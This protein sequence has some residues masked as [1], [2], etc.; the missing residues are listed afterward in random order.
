MTWASL[1]WLLVGGGVVILLVLAYALDFQR[2][3]TLMARIG[4]APQIARMAA[5]VSN[6]KRIAKAIL[7]VTAVALIAV[8]LAGPRVKGEPL[9][10]ERGIDVVVVIDVSKS[11]LARD[12]YPSRH[13][14]AKHV[15]DRLLDEIRGNRVGVVAFAGAAAHFPLTSDYEA[16][17]TLYHGLDPVDLPGGSDLGE[18]LRVARCLVVSATRDPECRVVRGE[19]EDGERRLEESDLGDRGRAIIL[20]TD[21]GDT[22]GEAR[23]QVDK[24]RAVG[25]QLFV[26]GVGT[27]AGARIPEV[28]ETGRVDGWKRTPDGQD[29]VVSKLEEEALAEL[30]GADSFYRDDGRRLPVEP[31]AKALGKLKE[32]DLAQRLI[33]DQQTDIYQFFL[34]PAFM[35]LLIEAC[36][37]D[38]RRQHGVRT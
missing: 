28:D 12:V 5:S 38:R 24:A 1:T 18:A 9:V 6:G 27:K 10:K 2:R 8:A 11:M 32:G 3:A 19:D 25:I 15:V 33:D 26:I 13:E 29:Y 36:L 30:A 16:A 4:H 22:E 23:T 35:L 7:T 31:I 37:S 34:F 17:R 20:V 14:R 21:G